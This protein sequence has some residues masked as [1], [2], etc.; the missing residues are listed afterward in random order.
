MSALEPVAIAGNGYP[1]RVGSIVAH[2]LGGQWMV[3]GIGADARRPLDTDVTIVPVDDLAFAI[4][5][6]SDE[7]THRVSPL[8]LIPVGTPDVV[9]H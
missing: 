5:R 7:F 8:S 6:R 1:V 9:I 3:T 4:R 2:A